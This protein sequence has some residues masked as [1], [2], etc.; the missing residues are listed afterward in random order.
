M[1][2][3]PP[4]IRV[5]EADDFGGTDFMS[6]SALDE[7]FSNVTSSFAALRHIEDHGISVNVL[8]KRKGGKRQ[9]APTYAKCQK[10]SGMLAHF[11]T[12]DFVIWLAADNIAEAEW[13]SDQIRRLLYHEAR[14][15]GWD[16]GDE[17]KDPKAI[18]LGHD[19]ELFVGELADT[20]AWE[21]FRQAVGK[22][23]KQAPLI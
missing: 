17:D 20:G 1:T 16:D 2:I 13:T 6:D 8:W 23:F 18:I 4:R 12:A 22:D 19:V 7:L 21:S 15:I 3:A 5:P 9:G 11:C 14:H 10:P